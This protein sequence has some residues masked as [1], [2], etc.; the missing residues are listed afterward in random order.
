[1]WTAGSYPDQ[2]TLRIG[3]KRYDGKMKLGV[4]ETQLYPETWDGSNWVGHQDPFSDNAYSNNLA[5]IAPFSDTS[6]RTTACIIERMHGFIEAYAEEL[7]RRHQKYADL[8]KMAEQ[9]RVAVA[10]K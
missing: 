10:E 4:E 3:I 5:S 2:V 8:R 9:I 1:M 7:K 6:R